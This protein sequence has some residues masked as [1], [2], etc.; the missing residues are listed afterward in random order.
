MNRKTL[1]TVA[2]AILAIG[3]ISVTAV[4]C[5]DDDSSSGGKPDAGLNPDTG[6]GI[7]SG[8]TD[9]GG[10]GG[11]NPAVPTLGAQ[12]DRMGRPAINTALNHTFDTN[13]TTK[14]AAKDS[15]NADNAVAGWKTKYLAEVSGNLAILDG[16]DTVCGNQFLSTGDAAGPAVATYGGLGGA[17]AD[18]RLYIKADATACTTYLAV[19]A[20][21]TNTIPNMDCGG[22]AL[23]YDV[24]DVTYSAAAIGAV[25]GVKDD[26]DRD[27]AKTGGATPPG[28][29]PYLATPLQ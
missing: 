20:N 5:G 15:Y 23:D 1:F 3:L 18:D 10:D 13:A 27:P 19:E 9:S 11:G 17:V 2:S 25:S 7:D 14:G 8:G 26:I 16:L 29:F 24:I 6:P 12:I 28:A 22:R 21:A 4:G